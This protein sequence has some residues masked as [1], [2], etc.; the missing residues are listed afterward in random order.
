M[1]AYIAVIVTFLINVTFVNAQVTPEAYLKKIPALP[2]EACNAAKETIQ[3]FKEQVNQ[4]DN[5]LSEDINA[6]QDKVNEKA[7]ATREGAMT[8]AAQ[9]YNLSDK[10]MKK[11]KKG[12]NLSAAE[13]Q[14]LANKMLNQQANMSLEEVQKLS[15]MNEAEKQAFAQSMAARGM[16][17]AQENPGKY[18]ASQDRAANLTR[19][20]N[21]QSALNQKLNDWQQEIAD[22]YAQIE[23]DPEGKAMLDSIQQ[24]K[25]EWNRLAGVD[26]GQGKKM[27]ALLDKIKNTQMKYYKTLTPRLWVVLRDHF[28]KVQSSFPD[29]RQ[30]DEVSSELMK[31]QVG[32][33]SPDAGSDLRCLGVIHAYLGK[34][35]QAYVFAPDFLFQGQ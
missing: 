17:D 10:D 32:V 2:K 33:P 22:R 23:N 19:L 34:L 21:E 14:E 18:K 35:Q 27:E 1:K 28:S 9:Q 24:W 31:A 11:I 25:S 20:V 5:Q 7:D 8:Y 13:T 16:K 3:N 6:R 12:E 30:L 29:C 26:Y 4:L 15:T